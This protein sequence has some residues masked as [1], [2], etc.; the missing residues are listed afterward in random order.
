MRE[1]LSTVI[2]IQALFTIFEA[3]GLTRAVLP[4]RYAFTVPGLK[5]VNPLRVTIPDL[6]VL[7]TSDYWGP[8][9]LWA[10]TSLLIPLAVGWFFNL[11]L[12]SSKRRSYAV[13]PLVYNIA[14]AITSWLVYSQGLR[15]WGLVSNAT[16]LRVEVAVPGGWFGIVI[17]SLVGVVASLYEAALRK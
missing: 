3:Y 9:S 13:D 1:A 14:K 2:G 12:H 10:T 16:A 8:T 7:L 15:F 17:G 5:V 6:F 4:W 11:T